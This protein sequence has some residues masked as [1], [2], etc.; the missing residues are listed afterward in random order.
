MKRS[1]ARILLAVL[2]LTLVL[3]AAACGNTK[4]P[5]STPTPAPTSSGN[6]ETPATETPSKKYDLVYATNASGTGNYTVAAAQG[7]LVTSKSNGQVNI[8]VMAT[9]GPEGIV[10]AI[11]SGSADIGI[12]SS[13]N[14]RLLYGE[15]TDKNMRALFCGGATMFGFVTREDSGIKTIEDLRGKRVTYKSPSSTYVMAAEAIL[16]GNGLDPEKDIKALTMTDAAAGLQDLVDGKTDVVLS[17]ISGSKM[18]ELSSKIAPYVIPV[19]NAEACAEE[20]GNFFAAITVQKPFPGA[21]EGQPIIGTVSQVSCTIDT[22]AEAVYTMVKYIMES[23]DE[24]KA[25]G[26]DLIDWKPEAAVKTAAGYPYHEGAVKY[27]KEAGMWTEEMDK[28]QTDTLEKLGQ[29]K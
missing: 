5:A 15:D 29:E 18:E 20:S 9:S 7:A 21:V 14:M 12:M 13:G 27:F 24:L 8:T 22:P 19:T 4:T 16:K 3:G 25:V 1:L 11:K 10:A 17:A 26:S 2:V 28:W 6:T 23:Y